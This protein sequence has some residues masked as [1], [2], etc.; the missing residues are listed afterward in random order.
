M[1]STIVPVVAAVIL[2]ATLLA[3]TV[4]DCAVVAPPGLVP[5]SAVPPVTVGV[6]PTFTVEAVVGAVASVSAGISKVTSKLPPAVTELATVLMLTVIDWFVIVPAVQVK[7]TDLGPLSP[8][9]VPIGTLSVASVV[10]E[11]VQVE[12]MFDCA[13]AVEWKK[14]EPATK[15]RVLASPK[16]EVFWAR[17]RRALDVST[18]YLRFSAGS[19]GVPG[20]QRLVTVRLRSYELTL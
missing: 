5:V 2:K 3:G 1:I 6:Q 8:V 17:R 9:P 11:A 15:R 16:A 14:V 10:V 12:V 19:T 18:V 13:A 4:V 20:F 7:G